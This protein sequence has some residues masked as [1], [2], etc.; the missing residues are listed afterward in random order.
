MSAPVETLSLAD[1]SDDLEENHGETTSYSI[2]DY[3]GINVAEGALAVMPPP[4]AP[5][6]DEEHRSD[7]RDSTMSR[8]G[9]LQSP[10]DVAIPVPENDAPNSQTPTHAGTVPSWS[11]ECSSNATRHTQN[12]EEDGIITAH[13]EYVKYNAPAPPG[14]DGFGDEDEEK[15]ERTDSKRRMFGVLFVTLCAIGLAIG[16]ALIFF[17]FRSTGELSTSKQNAIP[18]SIKVQNS[19]KDYTPLNEKA[20]VWLASTDTWE[21]DEEDP[22][23]D[24]L[25]LERY[26]MA[27]L[28]FSNNGQNW[29]QND[30]W[31]SSQPVCSWYSGT[32]NECPGPIKSLSL[33]SN[34]LTGSI[35]SMIGNLSQLTH[36]ELEDNGLTGSIPISIGNLRQLA[37][38]ELDDNSLTGSIP[39]S[40]GNLRQLTHLELDA[41]ELTGSI[42]ISIGNLRQLTTLRLWYCHLHGTIPSQIGN[43]TRLKVVQLDGNYFTGTLPSSIG[44]LRQ[45]TELRIG[46]DSQL[47][48]SLPSEIGNLSLLTAMQFDGNKLTGSLPSEIGNLRQLTGLWLWYCQLD[49]TIPS[50]IGNLTRLNV[51]LLDG[52]NF[53]GTL[54]SSI[55][56]L[57]QLTKLKLADNSLSGNIPTSIKSLTKLVSLDLGKNRLTG[58]VPPLPSSLD[59]CSLSRN[60]FRNVANSRDAG[61]SHTNECNNNRLY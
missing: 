14:R 46:K 23:G 54:P 26:S 1:S 44:N 59:T 50:E 25:W 58:S 20:F 24:Y 18:R 12:D 35:P 43:L 57:R 33:P 21:P 7:G 49:G 41:N 55:G 8:H 29:S 38:L 30:K 27:V 16:C 39:V 9:Y 52:N 22:N 3:L 61:C 6:R 60:C 51:V 48:G 32:A 53:S 2:G 11:V 56:S 37:H 31:L 19:L 42:P 28:Y 5:T 34:R 13:V 47:R 40:I 17:K 4:S 10:T 15:D 45:L 36:L